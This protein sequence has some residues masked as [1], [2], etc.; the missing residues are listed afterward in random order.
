MLSSNAH[1]CVKFDLELQRTDENANEKAEK[2]RALR[3]PPQMS[4][5]LAV[6]KIKRNLLSFLGV[7]HGTN[8]TTE[9]RALL[10][11]ECRSRLSRY[12]TTIAE[13]QSLLSK[14]TSS[15]GYKETLGVR[16]R[17]SEKQHLQA[18]I[19]HLSSTAASSSSS[20]SSSS[21]PSSNDEL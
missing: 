13:D 17:L 14:G 18:V 9:Q 7:L 4:F 2:L 21:S 11:K 19:D 5:C 20:S 16:F 1:D 8:D 10:V 6:G 15:M 12:S 3:M